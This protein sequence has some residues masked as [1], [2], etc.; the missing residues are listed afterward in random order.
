M[1]PFSELKISKSQIQHLADNLRQ[2]I[3]E[4]GIA[5]NDLAKHLELPVMTVRRLVSG[6]TSDPRISTLKLI[7]DYFNVPIDY[8]IQDE[9]ATQIPILQNQ[10]Q[11]LFIP[12]FDWQ[13]L[14]SLDS[15][16]HFDRANW[17]NW[18]PISINEHHPPG[19]RAFALPSKTTMQ[20]RFPIGTLFI[21]DPDEKPIDGDLVLVRMNSNEISLREFIIDPPNKFLQPVIHGSESIPYNPQLH[22]IIGVIVLTMLY[23]RNNP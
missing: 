17:K 13:T 18:H 15:M 12:I 20:P 5:E 8:L 21:V 2:L 14:S 23:T 3:T 7:A 19:K 22:N 4:R 10:A 16:N 6:E 9:Y 11:P 1:K